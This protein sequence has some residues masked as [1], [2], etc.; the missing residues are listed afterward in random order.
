MARKVEA[1]MDA[2]R[3]NDTRGLPHIIPKELID[4][5]F[6]EIILNRGVPRPP[7]PPEPEEPQRV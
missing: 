6:A 3:F 7:P 1:E 4:C 5:Y 2:R